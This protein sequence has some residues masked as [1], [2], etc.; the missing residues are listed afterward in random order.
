MLSGAR[1]GRPIPRR[2]PAGGARARALPSYPT[3][4]LAGVDIIP[5]IRR[6]RTPEDRARARPDLPGEP[7][8]PGS[9]RSRRPAGGGPACAW[10]IIYLI[11]RRPDHD[12]GGPWRARGSACPRQASGVIAGAPGRRAGEVLE[13]PGAGGARGRAGWRAGG[14]A[15]L[16]LRGRGREDG[17]GRVGGSFKVDGV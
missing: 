17:S 8:R 11:G 5:L 12:Q 13:D 14:A 9:W 2:P 6:G 4:D 10:C 7:R 3:A 1:R 15:G 16:R